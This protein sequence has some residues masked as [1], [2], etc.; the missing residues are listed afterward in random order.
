[1]MFCCASANR[2]F[3]Y[4]MMQAG[5]KSIAE[6]GLFSDRASYELVRQTSFVR[7]PGRR[8]GCSAISGLSTG[9]IGTAG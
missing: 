1:L 9:Q 4:R 7:V 8:A 2:A 3:H 6:T 5:E